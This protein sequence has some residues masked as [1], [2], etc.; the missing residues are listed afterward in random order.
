M[1]VAT[2]ASIALSFS[3]LTLEQAENDGVAASPDVN[4]AAAKLEEANRLYGATKSGLGPTLNAGYARTPQGNPPDETI[5][6]QIYNAG[7]AVNLEDFLAQ[8]TRVRDASSGLA[9][10]RADLAAAAREERVK[11][12]GLYYDALKARAIENARKDTLA[13]SMQIRDD[14]ARN[15]AT[16]KARSI[17]VTRASVA[18]SEAQAAQTEALAAY[19]NAITALRIETGGIAEQAFAA[20]LPGEMP[21]IDPLLLNPLKAGV[22]ALKSRSE[23]A[24]AEA[25]LDSA[26]AQAKIAR[27]DAVPAVTIAG[28]YV[29]GID[30]GVAIG[31]PAAAIQMTY[32]LSGKA[33]GTIGAGD[34]AVT[35]AAAK[36]AGAKRAVFLAVTQ[37]SRTLAGLRD[38]AESNTKAREEAEDELHAARRA[39]EH[40]DGTS[41]ELIT[42]RAAY[43]QAL[44][45]EIT[46]NYELVKAQKSLTLEIGN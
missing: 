23:I 7:L 41:L 6:Q 43:T 40:G 38:T 25:G 16:R 17:D 13:I 3:G 15:V 8:A 18:V 10:A 35:E 19:D 20:T 2:I 39:Y 45:N 9:G 12:L 5:T 37:A 26:K 44:V 21:F 30:A 28:G 11:V 31:G 42:A 24:A 4:I 46:S 29:G 22:A 27:W 32:P 1:L 36:L 34:A 14:S 33:A